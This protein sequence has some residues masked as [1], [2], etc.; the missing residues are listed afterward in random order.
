[1]FLS[2]TQFR[3]AANISQ[4]LAERW[5]PHVISACRE[6][7]ISTPQR[8]AAFIAQVGHESAGFSRLEENF[9]YSVN[10]LIVTYPRHRISTEQ[11]QAL[12]RQ[13]GEKKVPLERQ[14][15]IANLVYGNRFGNNAADGWRFR[16]R[17][18]KQITFHDNYQNCG[19]VLGV[20]L[21]EQPDLL[22]QDEYA[23][24]SAGWFW[25]SHGCNALAD[26]GDFIGLTQRINGGTN[27]L[28][29]RKSRH[30]IALG[31]LCP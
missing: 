9:N 21:V 3:Q 22:L 7:D 15:A 6:F 29:D 1:M 28:S 13:P 20:N 18:L 19:Q 10:G 26:A 2:I 17:G 24:R 27:G 23:A 14:V 11:A 16:G 4:Q 12:G 5:Y 31:V 25:A 8:I 30:A